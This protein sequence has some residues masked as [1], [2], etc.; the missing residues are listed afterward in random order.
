VN[1]HNRKFVY[2]DA[3]SFLDGNI[4]SMKNSAEMCL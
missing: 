1:A 2:A 4:A 3:T